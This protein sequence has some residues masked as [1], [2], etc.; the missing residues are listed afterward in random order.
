MSLATLAVT[1]LIAWLAALAQPSWAPYPVALL[2]YS[3][4]WL[5]LHQQHRDSR[6]LLAVIL[7]FVITA[8][9]APPR[10]SDDYHRY[11][12]EGHV[13]N[14]GYSPFAHPPDTLFDQLHH[15]AEPAI[16]HAHL[17]A[18][19]PP[20]SQLAFRAA[21]ALG[22]HVF[23]WKC[24]LLLAI[25][26]C[27]AFLSTR[28][29]LLLL[30]NPLLLVE[31]LW[32]A[33]LDALGIPALYAMLV[34]MQRGRLWRGAAAGIALFGIKLVPV[35]LTLFPWRDWPRRRQLQFAVLGVAGSLLL[36]LPFAEDGAALLRSPGAFSLH[37]YFN[38][39][40]FTALYP[41]LP[42]S[43]VR[44]LL[45]GI[46]LLTWLWLWLRPWR[47]RDRACWAWIALLCLS[48]TVYP[49]YLLWL[50][51]LTRSKAHPW[52]LAAYVFS[53]LSYRVLPNWHLAGVWHLPTLWLIVEWV[54][55]L[56]CFIQLRPRR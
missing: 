39:P 6:V 56:F 13:Q 54:G 44:A 37:W 49:W 8:L 22:H 15:P 47:V 53:C 5:R 21:D 34:F 41:A 29:T 51:P 7:P 38:N 42:A 20:L 36:Y 9:P 52:L 16:N 32:N 48:P 35:V 55:L 11:L 19:Y 46:M 27:R 31:G 14:H 26:S 18:I 23:P 25:L 43:W 4:A 12:W 17:P 50:L 1:A 45:T 10:L 3:L 24:L 33:H 28:Q 2:L 40:L 30:G